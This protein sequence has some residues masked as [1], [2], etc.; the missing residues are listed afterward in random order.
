MKR[1]LSYVLVL[2][3]ILNYV[4]IVG[5][6]T[7]TTYETANVNINDIPLDWEGWYH[8]FSTARI[9]RGAEIHINSIKPDGNII[10]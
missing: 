8:G 9:K 4:C 6:A 10:K 7:T 2:A 5:S 1:L 3:T